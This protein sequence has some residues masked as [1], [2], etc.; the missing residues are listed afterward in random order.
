MDEQE[1]E[2]E[3]GAQLWFKYLLAPFG[4]ERETVAMQSWRDWGTKKSAQEIDKAAR[5]GTD[6]FMK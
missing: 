4:S 3:E 1:K 6:L 2:I 5:E